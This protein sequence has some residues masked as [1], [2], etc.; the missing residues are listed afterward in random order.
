M[1]GMNE[2]FRYL[3]AAGCLALFL[4][5]Q[6][7]QEMAYR[8]WIPASHG[9]Q[10][11]LLTYLLPMDR[12]R[13]ILI[14]AGIAALVVPFVVIA[15]RCFQNA[16]VASTCGLIFGAAFIGFELSQRGVDFA[17]VGQIWARQFAQTSV[18]AEREALLRRFELWNE[19]VRGWYFPLLFS[20]LLASVSFAIAT[21]KESGQ[22]TWLRLAPVAF[23][24]NALRLSGRLLSSYA[25]QQWLNGL[26]ERL[27]FPAVLTI[28]I[29]LLT[30]FLLLAKDSGS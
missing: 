11:D 28:G 12:A 27:Y 6:T 13:A 4:G 22:S 29:L 7:F 30:W 25:G 19:I 2:K 10:N 26:N 17:M 9:P 16:P 23:V 18:E 3:L 8:F 21:W 15:L 5:S 20:Y 1:T 14:M 24:L